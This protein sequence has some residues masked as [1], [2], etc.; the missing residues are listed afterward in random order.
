M[1]EVLDEFRHVS[2]PKEYVF[3]VFPSLRPRQFSIASSVKVLLLLH[4]SRPRTYF[5]LFRRSPDTYSYVLQ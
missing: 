3:D 5:I 2:I 4:R 1:H